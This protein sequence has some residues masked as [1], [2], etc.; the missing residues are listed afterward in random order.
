[1]G[2]IFNWRQFIRTRLFEGVFSEEIEI[3]R[4]RVIR[5]SIPKIETCI[6]QYRDC[7][8]GKS[9]KIDTRLDTKYT[10]Q[11]F[12]DLVEISSSKYKKSIDRAEE[13]LISYF[14][15]RVGNIQLGGGRFS[16]TGDYWIYVVH[17]GPI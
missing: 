17:K 14:E 5:E 12:V 2:T 16:Y 7:K 3:E 10:R 13:Y 9:S 15:G 11:G 1:M 6:T 8:I 4:Q